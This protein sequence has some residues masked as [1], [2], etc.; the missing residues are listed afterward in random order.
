[1]LRMWQVLYRMH[2]TRLSFSMSFWNFT[3]PFGVFTS[4]AIALATAI[5]SAFFAYLSLVQLAALV[6]SPQPQLL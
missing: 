1:M 3:F 4:G 6:S 5:P 2:S